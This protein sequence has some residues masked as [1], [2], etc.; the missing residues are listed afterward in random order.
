MKKIN[1]LLLSAF[2]IFLFFSF[3]LNAKALEPASRPIYRGIDVSEWQRNI[4]FTKVKNSGIEIVY[5]R[6]SL[7]SNYIDPYFNRNYSEAKKN[8]LKVG[9]Y[10]Y[11]TAR[12]TSEAINE[13]RFF[14][15]VIKDKKID[16][17]L[18]MDFETFGN[19]NNN[20]INEISK[21][22]LNEVKKLTNK[23][24]VIYSDSSNAKNV[25]STEIARIAPLWVAEYG[26]NTPRS[27]GKWNN[28]VGWQYNDEGRINGITGYVDKDYFTKEILLNDN[29]PV[30]TKINTKPT[31]KYYY[32]KV[33]SGDTLSK[34]AKEYGTTVNNIASENNIRNINKIYVGEV[35][36]IKSDIDRIPTTNE[37]TYTVK[38][39]DTIKSIASK[40][41][42]SKNKLKAL[43]GIRSDIL[44][45]PGEEVIIKGN[46]HLD[47]LDYKVVK[48]NTLYNISKR[49][50]TTISNILRLNKIK[51]PNLI[52]PNEI[53]KVPVNEYLKDL[54]TTEF[55]VAKKGDT[56]E[57]ISKMFNIRKERL[58]GINKL[59]EN[60]KIKQDD[61]IKIK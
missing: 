14:A 9:V 35:L 52:Y 51:N 32:Y 24:M 25:F 49:Y 11:V 34:I 12:S 53:I 22:F 40:N 48:G 21:T 15:S 30:K 58:L 41:N 37:K 45:K 59:K 26:V 5:I 61:I 19:L 8:N 46:E 55:Y 60:Y 28:Y 27:N 44:L 29:S 57:S 38:Q 43:N 36:K 47:I 3:N 42:I 23:E 7:G 10:H 17:K 31:Y 54:N 1:T 18:A 39:G 13:A 33:K 4:N 16:A 20:Q 6:S 2:S 50:D 56:I